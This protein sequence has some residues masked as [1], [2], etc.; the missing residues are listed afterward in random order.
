MQRK[1]ILGANKLQL[2]TEEVIVRNRQLIKHRKLYTRIASVVKRGRLIEVPPNF[3]LRF[4]CRLPQ[5]SKDEAKRKAALPG[6]LSNCP[7]A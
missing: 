3:S 2:G 5:P 4:R 1:S 7:R 6:R